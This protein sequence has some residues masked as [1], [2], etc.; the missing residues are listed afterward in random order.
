MEKLIMDLENKIAS[1]SNSNQSS[2][3]NDDELNEN[4]KKMDNCKPKII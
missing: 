3:P 4:F 2:K 1:S